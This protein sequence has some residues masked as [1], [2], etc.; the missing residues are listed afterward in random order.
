MKYTKVFF[1]SATHYWGTLLWPFLGR[2]ILIPVFSVPI[3]GR[4]QSRC[5]TN[6]EWMKGWKATETKKEKEFDQPGPCQVYLPHL[7]SLLSWNYLLPSTSNPPRFP[8]LFTIVSWANSY[9]CLKGQFKGHFFCDA[10]PD[11]LLPL[12]LPITLITA[13]HDY[14]FTYGPHQ[15]KRSWRQGQS[16]LV[17]GI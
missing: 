8:H 1:F 10:L 9:I 3:E 17:T 15:T 14:P 16:S 13:A 7:F 12:Q 5:S 11:F 6:V 2:C 4:A